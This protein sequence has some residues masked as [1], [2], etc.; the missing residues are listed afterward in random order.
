MRGAP[1]PACVHLPQDCDLVCVVVIDYFVK[2]VGPCL[3]NITSCLAW[4]RTGPSHAGMF[5]QRPNASVVIG[6]LEAYA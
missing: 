5:Q 6:K 1:W 2:G 3:Q 4:M